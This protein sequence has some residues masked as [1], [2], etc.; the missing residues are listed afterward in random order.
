MSYDVAV[1]GGG[2]A[3]CEA[4]AVAA[5]MGARVAL[6]THKASDLGQLSCNPAIGGVG[7]GHLVR[8]IDALDGIMGQATD[9][10][11][12]HYRL[13]NRTKGVAVQGP[14]AQVDREQYAN[15]VRS[16]VLGSGVEVLEGQAVGFVGDASRIEGVVLDSGNA[17]RAS[18]TVVSSGTFL[19]ARMHTGAAHRDGGRYGERA[20]TKLLV[21]LQCLGLKFG[22]FKTGTPP[23]LDG[24]T[25]D[26]ASLELQAGDDAPV[27]LSSMTKRTKQP[28]LACALTRTNAYTHDLVR[29]NVQSSPT[30]SGAVIAAG[31]RHCPSL[32]D[33][34]ARFGDRQG[35]QIFLEPESLNG[36]S[37][38]PN[39]ISMA[40]PEPMQREVLRTIG[41]LAN[42]SILRTGYTIAYDYCLPGQLDSSLGVSGI[43]GLFL[44]G[45]INGTTG[46][47]EAAAQGLV[48]GIN[49]TLA[50]SG[51]DPMVVPRTMGYLGVLLSDVVSGQFGEPY[52]I[53]TSRAEHRLRFGINTSDARLLDWGLKIG[54][55]GPARRSHAGAELAKVGH[56][57]QLLA[58]L[59]ATAKIMIAAGA[60][61]SSD[62][63]AKS[64]YEWLSTPTLTWEDCENIWPELRSI[65]RE[66]A[67]VVQAECRYA[68]YLARA[69]R[70]MSFVHDIAL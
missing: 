48:A 39:G 66:A 67:E 12:I 29:Q 57:R 26:W 38:Y 11:A 55:V 64:A 34:I 62:G 30:Y 25:I 70:R 46:Y 43:A 1:I 18:Q 27:F 42:V 53:F 44:A 19:G 31:P 45:Q 6:I 22:R 41:G 63:M 2:H 50:S 33:K 28:Q 37:I 52:R 24:R 7:K 8:E 17:V 35:H 47:E 61:V 36:Y 3:G 20:S 4:A 5:R 13:L 58:S 21:A 60:K 14:R 40:L 59:N 68:P 23:R 9:A 56:T 54:C 69:E 49:A 15:A 65:E 32:E 51:R 16:L 10:A